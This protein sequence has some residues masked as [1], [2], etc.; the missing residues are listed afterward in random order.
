[1][2]YFLGIQ[3]V[4]QHAGGHNHGER[5]PNVHGQET[6]PE[7]QQIVPRTT[8]FARTDRTQL[9]RQYDQESRSVF[10]P[11]PNF[12]TGEVI[13]TEMIYHWIIF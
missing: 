1:M 8:K 5:Q 13:F 3:L 2:I 6:W 9:V 4:G 11:R 12:S 10:I 7:L